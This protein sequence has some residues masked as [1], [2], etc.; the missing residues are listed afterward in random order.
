MGYV[1]IALAILGVVLYLSWLNHNHP[2]ICQAFR[3]FSIAFFGVALLAQLHD[4]KECLTYSI[5]TVL[6]TVA[7][8]EMVDLKNKWSQYFISKVASDEDSKDKAER[9]FLQ[10]FQPAGII[11]MFLIA[12]CLYIN[13][14]LLPP[15]PPY[16]P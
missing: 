16:M 11:L 2:L 5:A 3:I 14:T 9:H 6:F 4:L 8:E 10:I 12:L 1:T 7:A 13:I 15:E